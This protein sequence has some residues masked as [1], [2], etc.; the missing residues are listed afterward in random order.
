MIP[1]PGHAELF[2]GIADMRILL[3]HS[4]HKSPGGVI[5]RGK[6]SWIHG[7]ALPLLA[8][9]TPPGHTIHLCNDAVHS[10]PVHGHWDLV[11]ISIMGVSLY[12]AMDIADI[13]PRIFKRS[14]RQS[15]S[16]VK[17]IITFFINLHIRSLTKNR[18]L[19]GT[20]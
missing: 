20:Y 16:F 15:G 10:L 1:L 8:A 3:V 11:G 19:P 9:A 17:Q 6:K 18:V 7:L 4:S 12:R 5:Y 2:T 13:F 14:I